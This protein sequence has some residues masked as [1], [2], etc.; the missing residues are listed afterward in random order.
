[1]RA[2]AF[3]DAGKVPAVFITE[4]AQKAVSLP[5][6]HNKVIF[7]LKSFS[8]I[9]HPRVDLKHRRVKVLKCLSKKICTTFMAFRQT[10]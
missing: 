3:V 8:I 1:V 6:T 9:I 10:L 7:K 5:W 4:L 2:A